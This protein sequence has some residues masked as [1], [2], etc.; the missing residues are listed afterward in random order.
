MIHMQRGKNNMGTII[1]ISKK[2]PSRKGFNGCLGWE[3]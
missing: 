3:T 1:E 2:N